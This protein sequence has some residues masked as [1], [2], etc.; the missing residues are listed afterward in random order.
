MKAGISERNVQDPGIQ[1]SRC[2]GAQVSRCP[3]AHA[4][5]SLTDKAHL[6]VENYRTEALIKFTTCSEHPNL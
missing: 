1:V 2:P 3:G 5:P 6:A 4:T